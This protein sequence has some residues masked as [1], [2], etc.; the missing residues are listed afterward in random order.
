MLTV[1]G[2]H[3]FFEAS[4]EGGVGEGGYGGGPVVAQQLFQSDGTRLGAR[5][6]FPRTLAESKFLYVG[7]IATTRG[8]KNLL[9]GREKQRSVCVV[10]AQSDYQSTLPITLVRA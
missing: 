1:L 4:K 6:I 7:Q 5:Q 9:H 2:D 8:R 3:V 10:G